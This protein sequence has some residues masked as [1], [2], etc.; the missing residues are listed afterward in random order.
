[1]PSYS[2]LATNYA[3]QVFL[4]THHMWKEGFLVVGVAAFVAIFMVRDFDPTF[5]YNNLL[6]CII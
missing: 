2:D 1:M 6:G 5:Q 3:M 4:F